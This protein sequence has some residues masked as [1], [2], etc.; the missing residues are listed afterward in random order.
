MS[1]EAKSQGYY[2]VPNLDDIPSSEEF[3]HIEN[4]TVGRTDHGKITWLKPVN[5]LN[6]G[7]IDDIVF[8]QSGDVSLYEFHE[9]EPARGKN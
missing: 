2:T 9:R 1:V 8:I 6:A 3:K 5:L 4:F 7:A